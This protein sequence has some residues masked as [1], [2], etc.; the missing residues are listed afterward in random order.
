MRTVVQRLGLM[1]LTLLAALGLVALLGGMMLGIPLVEL[2]DITLLFGKLG[3]AAGV[4]ALLVVQTRV[5]HHFGSLRTQVIVVI[6]L[7]GCLVAALLHGAASAMFINTDH[8]LPLLLMLLAFML[9]LAL[10]FSVS[11]GTII[12]RRLQVVRDGA[13]RLAQGDL[14]VRLPLTGRDEV[15]ALARDFNRMADAL[16]ESA[17]RQQQLE[18]ARHEL[19][20]AV[21]HDLRTPLTAVR[22]M[23]EALADGV[24]AD[25]QTSNRY[26]K[27]AQAQLE[28]LSTLVDDLFEIA[29]IDAGVLQIALERASLHDLVS[30]TLSNLQPHAER[31]GVRLIGEVAPNADVV[32][33]N[34][35]KLQRV[36]YNLIS[37]ALRH[38]PADGTITLRATNS[39][40]EVQVEVRD[41]GEGISAEDLPHIFERTY[42]GEKSRSRDYGGAGLGLAIVRGLIE[43]HGGRIWVE[44]QPNQGARFVFTLRLARG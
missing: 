40:D 21:S 22:A 35:P 10:G 13:A 11:L 7:G 2:G 3:L 44:S 36:L 6:T 8:D 23:V 1:L 4:V 37:N 33:M 20:A 19:I 30:D 17:A 34:P 26:L 24:V 16:A 27:S 28:N 15:T 43:A 25:P 12:V 41:E 18:H 14:S 5:L 39:G 9:V 42:R 32:L 38:T 29:Q 31:Q